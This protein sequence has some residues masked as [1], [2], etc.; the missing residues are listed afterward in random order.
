MKPNYKP[1]FDCSLNE[2]LWRSRSFRRVR[3]RGIEV[4]NRSEMAPVRCS[5]GGGTAVK[6]IAEWFVKATPKR[7]SAIVPLVE[8]RLE[9]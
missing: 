2:I 3:D 8:K 7:G 9:G 1:L 5:R 6:E 4:S